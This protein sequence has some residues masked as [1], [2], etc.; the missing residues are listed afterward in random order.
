MAENDRD[1]FVRLANKRV[2]KAVNAI[3]LIGNLSN[4]SNYSFTEQDIEKIF[5]VLHAELKASKQRF[6]SE[7][8][9]GKILFQLE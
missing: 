6:E 2:N 3:R 4:R 5:R 9:Q 7:S 8:L 1:K